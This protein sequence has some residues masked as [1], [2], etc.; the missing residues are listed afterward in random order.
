MGQI[1][2]IALAACYLDESKS[3]QLSALIMENVL[4][5]IV[6]SVLKKLTW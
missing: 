4:S 5:A 2:H 3:I 6:T 1:S